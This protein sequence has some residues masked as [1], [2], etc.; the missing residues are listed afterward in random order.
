MAMRGPPLQN[1]KCLRSTRTYKRNI[2]TSPFET[3]HSS[4]TNQTNPIHSTMSNIC[5]NNQ[6]KF[7]R[8]HKYRVRAIYKP[9][10]SVNQRY[11]G[12]KQLGVKPF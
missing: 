9:K 7:L 1:I 6:T 12:L 4:R 2:S 11:T 3:I 8:S 5:L 10:S